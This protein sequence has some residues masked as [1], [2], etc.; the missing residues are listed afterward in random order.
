M[1]AV[2]RHKSVQL[3]AAASLDVL[4]V[5][6]SNCLKALKGNRAGQRSQRINDQFRICFVWTPGGPKDVEIVD[7]D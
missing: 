4:R 6:P 2:A 7:R 3:N 5:P 1:Q